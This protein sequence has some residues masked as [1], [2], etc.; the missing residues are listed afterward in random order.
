VK[1]KILIVGGGGMG[2]SIAL[3]AATRCDPLNEPV[4]L[5]EKSSLGAG[6]S[7]RSGAIVHAAYS[8][9]VLA[10]MARDSLKQ[11]THIT[12]HTGRSVG[13]RKTGVLFLPGPGDEEKANYQA[14][15]EMQRALGIIANEVNADEMR[16]LVS[17]IEVADDAVGIWQPEGGFLDPGRTINTIAKLARARG[18]TTRSGVAEP[19]V[20]VKNG[21]VTG[22]ETDKGFIEADHV[23]LATGAWTRVLLGELGVEWPL[24]V[25]RTE[26]HFLEMPSVEANEDD[27]L[28]DAGGHETRFLPDPLESLP[29]A[30]PVLIDR[31]NCFYIR[32]DPQQGRSRVGR[33]GFK[34]LPELDTPLGRSEVATKEFSEWAREAVVQRLPAYR[35]LSDLGSNAAHISVTPDGRGIVGE[36]PSVKGLWIVTGFSGLDYT[37]APSI[38]EGLVQMIEGRPVAAFKPE[39]FS[40][41]RFD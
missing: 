11:Y 14:D 7:G 5:I 15:L 25:L 19:H 27:D 33:I 13:Y 28:D 41:A 1:A 20:I 8:D 23:V 21:C 4:I 26:E 38:G 36:V 2:V 22:V 34:N 40:P 32:C 24:Q 9:R 37:L 35:D 30:H 31:G 29:V 6:S 16:G 17:G 18:A 39:F 10:G 3:H 12:T